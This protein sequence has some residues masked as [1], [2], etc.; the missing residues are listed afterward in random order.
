MNGGGNI[1]EGHLLTSCSTGTQDWEQC[2]SPRGRRRTG[3]QPVQE[4]IG[5]E[6]TVIDEG[7]GYEI[8]AHSGAYGHKRMV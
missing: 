2:W 5:R 3:I 1:P 6:F 7:N 4:V 8:E